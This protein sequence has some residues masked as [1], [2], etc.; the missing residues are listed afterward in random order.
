MHFI[1]QNF[2]LLIKKIPNF[3]FRYFLMWLVKLKTFLWSIMLHIVLLDRMQ[4]LEM[5]IFL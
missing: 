3:Y 4:K 2:E 1:C 5:G